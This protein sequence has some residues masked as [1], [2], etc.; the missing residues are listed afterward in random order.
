[1][2]STPPL[3]TVN[4]GSTRSGAMACDSQMM[5]PEGQHAAGVGDGHRQADGH[6]LPRGAP[7]ADDV[8]GHHRLAV[9]GRHGVEPTQQDGDEERQQARPRVRS[10]SPTVRW[11]QDVRGSAPRACARRPARP[12]RAR[13]GAPRA[14]PPGSTSALAASS[15]GGDPRSS[16]RTR[17]GPTSSSGAHSAGDRGAVAVQRDLPPP[18][19][20]GEVGSS[21]V[22]RLRPAQAGG[23]RRAHSRRSVRSPPCPGRRCTAARPEARATG[24]EPS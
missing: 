17:A 10:R 22:S 19:A 2:A 11:N 13:R 7:A 15:R 12:G 24:W 21:K 16:G 8:G 3:A 18:D 5:V 4:Q 9:A 1:M 20:I 6:D 23:P 14:G